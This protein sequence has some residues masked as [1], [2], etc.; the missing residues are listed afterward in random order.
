MD[1]TRNSIVME[2][3]VQQKIKH[4]SDEVKKLA[5]DILKEKAL[6][7]NIQMNAELESKSYDEDDFTNLINGYQYVID[8]LRAVCEHLHESSWQYDFALKDLTC[9]KEKYSEPKPE[10]IYNGEI[11]TVY[12][13]LCNIRDKWNALYYPDTI[14]RRKGEFKK[15]NECFE[16]WVKEIF[17]YTEFL[18]KKYN[19]LPKEV[20]IG[21]DRM[22]DLGIYNPKCDKI[23][24]NRRLIKDPVYALITVIHE[25]CHVKYS[26]HNQEFWRLYEDVCINEG[27]LLKRVLGD[28]RSLREI[29]IQDIPYRWAPVIDYFTS[30]EQ[31]TIEKC[32]KIYGIYSKVH[33][34][35]VNSK[36]HDD[37]KS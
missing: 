26:N 11:N 2:N 4:L 33:K 36:H 32:M 28:R 22:E 29:K 21:G 34:F 17:E 14:D 13:R 1:R 18:G 7:E 3:S 12:S 5:G 20:K 37:S 19:L 30:N 27:L 35:D 9:V 31:L 25:L 15:A 24:Y 23:S 16:S 6:A 10:V 8:D